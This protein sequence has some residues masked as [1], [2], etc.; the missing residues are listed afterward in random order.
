MI[1]HLDANAASPA[2]E[3]P[4]RPD[5][6]A[7]NA[8]GQ[9]FRV[10]TL[11]DYS[12]FV[13]TEKHLGSV[14]YN[15]LGHYIVWF[16]VVNFWAL[17]V[18]DDARLRVSTEHKHFVH[19]KKFKKV[20]RHDNVPVLELRDYKNRDEDCRQRDH[21]PESNSEPNLRRSDLVVVQVFEPA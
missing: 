13:I 2:M 14:R 19:I 17:N 16:R 11:L 12:V 1:M 6:I 15:I 21:E 3:R 10:L 9:H 8:V 18:G 5:N 20:E 4:R 7:C